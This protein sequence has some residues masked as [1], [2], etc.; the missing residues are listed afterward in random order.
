MAI[1]K[2]ETQNAFLKKVFFDY[3]GVWKD[4]FSNLNSL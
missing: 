2:F 4:Y 3:W 1:I